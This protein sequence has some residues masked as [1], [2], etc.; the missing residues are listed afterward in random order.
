MKKKPFFTIAA[1][2]FLLMATYFTMQMRG[3][4]NKT[5]RISLEGECDLNVNDICNGFPMGYSLI[6]G[7]CDGEFC[8][9]CW[10]V[11]CDDD[12]GIVTYYVTCEPTRSSDCVQL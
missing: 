6:Y 12:Y 9:T 4:G 3:S 11:Y 2:I 7:I 8:S 5:C 10:R 1:I